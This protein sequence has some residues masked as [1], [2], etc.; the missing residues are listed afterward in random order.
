MPHYFALV[1]KEEDSAFGITFPDVPN[2]FSASDD[3][4]DVV[5]NATEALSFYAEDEVLPVPR[6]IDEL[7]ANKSI[8]KALAHGAFLISVPVIENDARVVRANITMEAGLLNAIDETAKARKLT[9]SAFLAQAARRE[10]GV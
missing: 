7:K 4:N 1:E 9:R 2:C 6:S 8:T 10:M 3:L 5:K